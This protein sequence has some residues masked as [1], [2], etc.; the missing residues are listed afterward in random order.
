MVTFPKGVNNAV[1]ALAKALVVWKSWLLEVDSNV[2]LHK[3]IRQGET[4]QPPVSFFAGAQND[5]RVLSIPV[6]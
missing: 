5:K 2:L 3:S 4:N 1:M 6:E